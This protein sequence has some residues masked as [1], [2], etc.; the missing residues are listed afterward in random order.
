LGFRVDA[1]SI[2]KRFDVFLFTSD[3]EPFGLVLVEAM[4]AG[5]P[6]VA[7]HQRG[8]VHEII[9]NCVD[10]FV[11]DE[12]S[13]DLLS[14]RVNRVLGD[15]A[16]SNMFIKNAREKTLRRFSIEENGRRVWELYSKCL[17]T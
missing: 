9:E 2:L 4:A 13:P 15:V 14:E 10:G 6:I 11:V 1:I 12:K 5:I 8:A 16:T 17:E 3:Y 7:F